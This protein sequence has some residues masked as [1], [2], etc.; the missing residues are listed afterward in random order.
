MYKALFVVL[1]AGCFLAGCN[2]SPAA[3][4][5]SSVM[6]PAPA[7]SPASPGSPTSA[8]GP[9]E[10]KLKE[11][12]GRGATNCG[13][14]QSQA[15]EQMDAAAKCSMQAAQAKRPFYVAYDLPGMTVAIAGNSAGKLFSVGS[16]GANAQTGSASGLASGDC[17]TSLR[18]A[19]SGRV[20]CFAPGTFPMGMGA[21]QS[22]HGSG[23]MPPAS[24]ANPHKGLAIPPPGHPSSQ[25][26]QSA[27][28]PAKQP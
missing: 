25:S 18:V 6:S 26:P 12:A 5:S 24:G 21:G 17:P 27:S 22:A 7:S 4:P 8:G 13:H 15:T 20:T 9:V 2:K 14:L 1:M 19:P 11:L 23:M 28:P 16:Q 3:S 10:E